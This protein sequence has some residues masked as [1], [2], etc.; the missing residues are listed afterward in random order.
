MAT[1]DFV[2]YSPTSGNKNATINVTASKN[3]SSV[4]STILN[5]SAKGIT[6]SININ[7]KKGISVAVIVGQ[8]GNIF[9]IQLE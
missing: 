5:I 2:T 7:Q 3:T 4:R 1:K 8:N 9:K 6:K